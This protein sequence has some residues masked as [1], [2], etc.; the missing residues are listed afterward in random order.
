MLS[1]V[2]VAN[3]PVTHPVQHVHDVAKRLIHLGHGSLARSLGHATPARTEM[4]ALRTPI[5]VVSSPPSGRDLKTARHVPHRMRI[6]H[7]T[8]PCCCLLSTECLDR[9]LLWT[10]IAESAG[11]WRKPRPENLMFLLSRF[12]RACSAGSG[13]VGR[14]GGRVCEPA[15]WPPACSRTFQNGRGL[16]ADRWYICACAA[17]EPRS[18][19]IAH[20]RLRH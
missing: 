18:L 19:L 10:P 6:R 13:C 3:Q 5:R 16:G 2:G 9:L 20:R 8:R 7:K 15:N 4:C 1:V 12:V 14:L 17:T 11:R